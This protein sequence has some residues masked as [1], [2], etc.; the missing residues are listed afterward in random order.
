MGDHI[1]MTA[2]SDEGPEREMMMGISLCRNS[3]LRGIRRARFSD[4]KRKTFF[5]TSENFTSYMI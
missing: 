5:L 3:A 2:P 4:L 1:G